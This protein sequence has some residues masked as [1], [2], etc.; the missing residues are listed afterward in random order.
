[1][2]VKALIREVRENANAQ[3][4]MA[5]VTVEV[6]RPLEIIEMRLFKQSYDDG[7]VIRFK[8]L[9]GVEIDLPLQVEVYNGR[10]SYGLPFGETVS[11][12]AKVAPVGS[13][14]AQQKPAA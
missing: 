4:P 7:T 5:I 9:A 2:L 1:M 14:G 6:T 10:L 11:V 3:K 12:P 13:A 8:Q